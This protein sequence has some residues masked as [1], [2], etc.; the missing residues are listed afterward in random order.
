MTARCL[1]FIRYCV[2]IHCTTQVN[3]H[4]TY[5]L[6]LNSQ[7]HPKESNHRI[8]GIGDKG[9]ITTSLVPVFPYSPVHHAEQKL[10]SPLAQGVS[11]YVF[12]CSRFD[13][14]LTVCYAAPRTAQVS[15]RRILS[16]TRQEQYL[17]MEVH[18][19]RVRLCLFAFVCCLVRLSL[20]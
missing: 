7:T 18:Y 14:K 20:T 9:Q 5:I 8:G 1:L 2:R 17:R 15:H 19:H 10:I 13:C 16:R 4:T 6:L 3:N 11:A 12:C